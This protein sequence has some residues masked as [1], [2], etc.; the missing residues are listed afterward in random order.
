M[1]T[2]TVTEPKKRKISDIASLKPKVVDP[3][4]TE[5]NYYQYEGFEDASYADD[6]MAEKLD[7]IKEAIHEGQGTARLK[8]LH[9]VL[10]ILVSKVEKLLK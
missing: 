4:V 8:E 10:K 3:K 5:P 1:D 2:A 6:A 9:R 7:Y